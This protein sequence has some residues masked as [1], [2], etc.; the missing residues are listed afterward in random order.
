MMKARL[1]TWAG[2]GFAILIAFLL[3]ADGFSD[4]NLSVWSRLLAVAVAAIVFGQV[5]YKQA[6]IA[7]RYEGWPLTRIWP[8]RWVVALWFASIS[9][10]LLWVL[11][12]SLFPQ[13]YSAPVAT[14]VWLQFIE[15]TLFFRDRWT[16]VGRPQ[17]AG[18]GETGAGGNGGAS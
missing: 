8:F 9:L 4:N 7:R 18:P 3:I 11:F 1:G 16:S 14:V 10:L 6:Q 15:A 2:R 17:L 5:T 13:L 12:R